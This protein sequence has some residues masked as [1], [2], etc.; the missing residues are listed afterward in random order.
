M[1][2]LVIT[3]SSF[4][5]LRLLNF[6][7]IKETP[8]KSGLRSSEFGEPA[9]IESEEKKLVCQI[10][11]KSAMGKKRWH[12]P[13]YLKGYFPQND[14]LSALKLSSNGLMDAL[15]Q[16]LCLKVTL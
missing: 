7:E 5:Y 2:I 11:H 16:V 4:I 15:G 9:G 8:G 10:Y 3:E 12:F 6:P 1:I 13:N 14:G